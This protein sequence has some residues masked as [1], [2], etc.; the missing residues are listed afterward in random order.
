MQIIVSLT[1]QMS[2]LITAECTR[3]EQEGKAGGLLQECGEVCRW[4]SGGWS[5]GQF[6]HVTVLFAYAHQR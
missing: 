3:E 2:I 5:E 6:C 4:S 1:L